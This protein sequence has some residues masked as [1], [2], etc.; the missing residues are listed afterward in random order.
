MRFLSAPP[1]IDEGFLILLHFGG[2]LILFSFVIRRNEIRKH[3][4]ALAFLLL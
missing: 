4:A 1:K 2:S 3:Y